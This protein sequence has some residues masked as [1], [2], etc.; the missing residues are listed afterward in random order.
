MAEEGLYEYTEKD[1]LSSPFNYDLESVKYHIEFEKNNP[2]S[3]FP[4]GFSV[5][6]RTEK[7]AKVFEPT[8]WQKK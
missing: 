5:Y 8:S 1:M 2:S 3:L 7:A 6:E 4:P